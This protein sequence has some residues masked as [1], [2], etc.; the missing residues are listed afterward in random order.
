M[1]RT[2]EDLTNETVRE[3]GV[4][5]VLYFDMH[6]PEPEKLKQIATEFVGRITNEPGVLYAQGEVQEPVKGEDEIYSTNAEV[7]VLAQSL[8]SLL[9]ISMRYGPI[10]VEILRPDNHIKLSLGEAHDILLLA[11]QNSFEF[12]RFVINNV[13]TP[14]D[15]ARFNKDAER[16]AEMGKR[17]LEKKGKDEEESKDTR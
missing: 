16:R 8:T 3:G 11:A 4:F 2:L 13:A 10:G 15:K 14:E 1:T 6:S 17:L 7:H 5:A 9:G 12:S